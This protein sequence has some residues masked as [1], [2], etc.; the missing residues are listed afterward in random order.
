M[1]LSHLWSGPMNRIFPALLL[2]LLLTSCAPAAVSAPT[3]TINPGGTQV[4]TQTIAPPL[5]TGTPSIPPT[6]A[7]SQTVEVKLADLPQT[8]AAV[9]QFAAAM[10]AAGVQVD[11]DQVR[12]GLTT[13]VITGKDGKKYEIAVTQN[14]YPLMKRK[15]VGEWKEATLD[16][17]AQMKLGWHFGAMLN[18]N[19]DFSKIT[20]DNFG[21]GYGF[22]YWDLVQAEKGKWDFSDPDYNIRTAHDQGIDVLSGLIWGKSVP[23][24]VKQ[25]PAGDL[26]AA[27]VDYI[28]QV[29]KHNQ[30]Q[31][32]RWIVYNEAAYHGNGD[33]YWNK[34]GGIEAVRLAFSTARKIDPNAK[35]IYN[36]YANFDGAS[37]PGDSARLTILQS[38]IPQLQ[39][40]GNIDGIGLQVVS[41]T[42]D[43]DP[44]KLRKTLDILS[45]YN[46]PILIT[47]YS[48]LINGE[49][50]PDNM[51]K[52]AEVAAKVI[53]IFKEYQNVVEIIAFPLEDR[54]AN[55]IYMPNSN[56]GLWKK[57]E[58][59]TYIPKPI[60]YEM[61]RAMI[62]DK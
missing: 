1:V 42:L 47:E 58:S 17:I 36:D 9:D 21:T 45:K 29:M 26:R 4:V 27:M 54:L 53:K 16:N 31:V 46:L 2:V 18:L 43:F 33:V 60:V 7:P 48:I 5:P 24:W 20:T 12:Q 41:R 23:E 61:M 39:M 15:E 8:K 11:A 49:N 57:T 40:D 32:S 28:Q 50:T 6:I 30:G 14:G 13:K 51:V 44:N 19:K 56:S 22:V 10:K 38:I 25:L 37:S 59:G 3:S 52:Q 62:E 55:K 35:L 34:L